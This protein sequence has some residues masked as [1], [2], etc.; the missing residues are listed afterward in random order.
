L[1][2]KVGLVRS[3]RHLYQVSW[4]SKIQGRCVRQVNNWDNWEM[5][6]KWGCIG[7]WHSSEI[8]ESKTSKKSRT[9]ERSKTS[10]CDMQ[11]K[12]DRLDI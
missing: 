8:S 2:K 7:L 11:E 1:I 6:D 10:E 3:V 4:T 5:L 9:C 12:Q